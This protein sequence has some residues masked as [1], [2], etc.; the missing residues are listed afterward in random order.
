MTVF[1]FAERKHADQFQE[2]FGGEIIDPG[3]RP[4]WPGTLKRHLT[5]P[6]SSVSGTAVASI[7]TTE[8]IVAHCCNQMMVL[9][10]QRP[11]IKCPHTRAG[12]K[13]LLDAARLNV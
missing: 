1:C 9:Q 2:R 4:K 11:T 3:M 12:R 13:I 6:Q 5:A 8:S 10:L 7:A